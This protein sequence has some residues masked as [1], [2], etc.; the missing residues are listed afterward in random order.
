MSDAN[1]IRFDFAQRTISVNGVA[2]SDHV[3]YAIPSGFACKLMHGQWSHNSGDGA[4]TGYWV[5]TRGGLNYVL[6]EPQA[7]AANI[8]R[9]L[10]T[11][12]VVPEPLIL[13]YGDKLTLQLT[14][15]CDAGHYATMVLTFEEI[16]GETG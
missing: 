5:L 3:S 10:Y 2:A 6:A 4:R 12:V 14:G 15:A 11:D 13:R 8:R 16:K 1:A 7:L 9:N